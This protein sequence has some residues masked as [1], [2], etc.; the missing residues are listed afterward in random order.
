MSET[1]TW[2]FGTDALQND[3]LTERRIPVVTSFNPLWHYTMAFLGTN[4]DTGQEWD[5]PWLFASALRPTEDEV[6]MLDSF[7]LYHRHYWSTAWGYRMELLDNRPLDVDSVKGATVFIKYGPDDWAYRNTQ[8]TSGPTFVPG[9][10]NSRGT[11]GPLRLDQ[12][13][14]RVHDSSAQYPNQEW[15]QWKASHPEVFNT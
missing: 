10:P 5:P 13:M 7:R 9:P 14:D 15:R 12:V 1:K 6:V 8:W 3:P 11:E 4:E 2:P